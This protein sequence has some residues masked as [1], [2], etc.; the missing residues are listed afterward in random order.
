MEVLTKANRGRW[1]AVVCCAIVSVVVLPVA[2]SAQ[3]VRRVKISKSFTISLPRD[4]QSTVA[5]TTAV[6]PFT[7]KRSGGFRGV[8]SFDVLDTPS[9]VTARIITRSTSQYEVQLATL[10]T[11]PTGSSVY[12]L[13]GTAGNIRKTVP[14]RLTVSGQPTTTATS[15]ASTTPPQVTTV[16]STAPTGDF[17]LVADVQPSTTQT[18]S[19]GQTAQFGIRVDRRS[20]TAPVA[21]KV[22]GLPV[23]A[24]ASF[25]PNPS[26]TNT[27]LTVTTV[28]SVASGTYL[29]VI[30][31]SA[32]SLTRVVAVRLVVRRAAQFLLT[33][34]PTKLTVNAGNDAAFTVSVGTPAGA[35]VLADVTVDLV[36]A[37]PGV[38]LQ[39][40]TV[41]GQ[42]KSFVLT[43]SPDT[44]AGTYQLTVV[45]V[46][47][48]FTQ[49]L[50]LTLI[51]TRETQGFGL[52]AQPISLTVKQGS[53]GSYDV[54][55]VSLNG[56]KGA[57]A[58]TVAG[59]PNT[60]SASVDP[61]S[62]G[63]T[64]KVTTSANTPAT[65]YPV[66]IT[67]K[68]GV[69]SATV[70]VVLVVIAPSS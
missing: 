67:G 3:A 62:T 13:R 57:V 11:T 33:A 7:F 2:D 70:A 61:T 65:S 30:T 22:E 24:T 12:F 23:G 69:L 56:F 38:V 31:G 8:V 49:R 60:A 48:A 34:I 40:S 55:L 28:A 32:N 43:T 17:T 19:P 44:A 4:S 58:F 36:G 25:N 10:P 9:G 66:L 54:K 6:F 37:P 59:L 47:G 29:L 42:N 64:V 51:V 1:V 16:V 26:Q 15:I 63:V 46:S 14:F 39:S 18:I 21:L 53:T 50:D 35:T 41:T 27:D 52:S 68:N 20:F 45:G 5:G